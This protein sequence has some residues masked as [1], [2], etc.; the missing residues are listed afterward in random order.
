[1]AKKKRRAKGTE[2]E[3]GDYLQSEEIEA[4]F[5][6]VTDKRDR[7]IFALA[8]YQG[9]RAHE[10]G[11]LQLADYRERDGHLF[12]H[13]GKNS[14]SRH[15]ALTKKGLVAIRA[16][17]KQRGNAPGPLF[18]S[19][20]GNAGITRGRLDQMMKHYGLLAGIPPEKRHMHALKHSC[21]THMSERGES[22]EAIQD[23]LGHRD[24]RSTDVYM[25]FSKR[26]RQEVVERNRDW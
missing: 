20:Q 16:W 24:P 17:I 15:Y 4:L 18:P 22:A 10:V 12:I 11:L 3:E 26:R 5:R 13:R 8:Y 19:R 2:L 6:V 14:I 1:M 25:H 23:W 7:A 9:L 21:G